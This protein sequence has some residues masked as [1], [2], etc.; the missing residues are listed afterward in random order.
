MG[1][2]GL[3]NWINTAAQ[4]ENRDQQLA[5]EEEE[6]AP[7]DF[8]ARGSLSARG[9]AP[10]GRTFAIATEAGIVALYDSVERKR[11][12]TL[13][14]HL[15]AAFGVVFSAD[16]KR[17]VSTGGGR[18]AAKIWD[19]ATRQELLTLAGHGSLL[20]QVEFTEDGN[21]LIVGS[22]RQVGMCQFWRAPSWREIEETERTGGVWLR[23]GGINV[24][25]PA[26]FRLSPFALGLVPQFVFSTSM[27]ASCGMFTR[28]IAFIR[29]LPSF[30]FSSS[31]RLRV[32]SPP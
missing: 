6:A 9:F 29:F 20:H 11:L 4:V 12:A 15:Q 30:C 16:G 21:T 23:G 5:E 24:S 25:K 28:P 10:D 8:W 32:M 31:L 27:N 17:L 1:K 18:E 26:A 3:L 22:P 14:G 2:S 13:H 19:V 7:S